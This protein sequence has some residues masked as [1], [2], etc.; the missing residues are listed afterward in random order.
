M[1]TLIYISLLL[2]SE[3]T[4]IIIYTNK[5]DQSA[6]LLLIWKLKKI[7]DITEQKDGNINNKVRLFIN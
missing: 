6:N 7:I 5:F 2:I 4:Q 3:F 1:D